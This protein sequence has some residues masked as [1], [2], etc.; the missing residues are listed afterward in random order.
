MSELNLESGMSEKLGQIYLEENE[1]V[2]SPL[3]WQVL[4]EAGYSGLL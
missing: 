1:K 3:W 2:K 4:W